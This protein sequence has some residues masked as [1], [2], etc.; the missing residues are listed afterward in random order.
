[1]PVKNKRDGKLTIIDGNSTPIET[2]VNFAE[3]DLTF[4]EPEKAEPIAIKNRQGELDH[5]KSSDAFNG[6]GK[7]SFTAKYVDKN[8]KERATNPADV[9]AVEA[10]GIP[11]EYPTVNVKYEIYD[12]TNTVAETYTFFNVFFDPGKC[13]FNEGD[14]A[15]TMN[16]EG[17]IFGKTN[18]SKRIFFEVS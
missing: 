14:E 17:I 16:Y 8:I 6:W 10:D 3:G 4:N 2:E 15:S 18:G 13:T 12:D 7:I 5:L 11:I 1:M 9:T